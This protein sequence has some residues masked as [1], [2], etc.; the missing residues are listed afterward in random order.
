[1]RLYIESG[2]IIYELPASLSTGALKET[3]KYLFYWEE[4]RTD[5]E[6]DEYRFFVSDMLLQPCFFS[7]KGN[8][9]E[10]RWT[11]DPEFF[12]GQFFPVLYY[13]GRKIWPERKSSEGI[14]VD[15]DLDKLTRQQF[16]SMVEEVSA[17]AFSLS[18]AFH[19]I[20][21]GM[22]GRK[23]A[24]VQMELMINYLGQILRTV[25][26]I[27]RNPKKK[28][29][30]VRQNVPFH[31]ARQ[32]DEHAILQLVTS[33]ASFVKCDISLIPAALKPLTD[34]TNNYLFEKIS[35]VTSHISY[36]TY[37]NAFVKGFLLQLLYLTYKLERQ[38]ASMAASTLRDQIRN[39][40][41][42]RLREQIIS[43]R[44]AIQEILRL[45]FLQEVDPLTKIENVTVT[46]LK[47]P[48]YRRLYRYYQKFLLN[49]VPLGLE[50]F[51]LSLD[52][53]Y[54]LY[55]YWCFMKVAGFLMERYGNKQGDTSDIFAISPEHG[56]ISLRLQHGQ[57][58]VVKINN[59]LKIYFQR[60]YNY[61]SGS[62]IGS[63]SFEMRPDIII[64][65]VDEKG[66]KKTIILDPKYRVN[67]EGILTA[68]GE[69]HKYKD[70]LVDENN[71]RIIKAAFILVPNTPLTEDIVNRYTPL[72]YKIKHG[73]GVCVLTPG[74]NSG[75]EALDE[76]LCRTLE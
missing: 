9:V 75:L 10:I 44:K 70:A 71:N 27:A 8:Q 62:S 64:E 15:A 29:I 76:L 42:K 41:A 52:R 17:I 74:D 68:L 69:M 53:T 49:A 39:N 33:P 73:L 57:Q 24:L 34:R 48:D 37:E 32:S 36:N 72:E 21:L 61:Y 66:T 14:I 2:G 63:Y 45:T 54:Q 4:E 18:P 16:C 51:D 11:W 59:G 46:M 22:G 3:N 65:H 67:R 55:E 30:N 40:L 1:M 60:Q 28:L 38:L 43:F 20:G 26:C 25:K 47:H 7:A 56:G 58:S 35:E 6:L 12:S 31:Q 23:F 13:K 50:C 5:A 19:C